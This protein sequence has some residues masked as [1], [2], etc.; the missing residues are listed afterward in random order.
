MDPPIQCLSA[1]KPGPQLFI[2]DWLSRLNNETN[3]DKR[4]PGMC[5]TINVIE[6]GRDILDCMTAEEILKVTLED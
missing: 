4:I 5:I 6:T 1:M 3:R 2:A